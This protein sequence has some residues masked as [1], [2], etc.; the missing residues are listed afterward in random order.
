MEHVV[1]FSTTARTARTARIALEKAKDVR[2]VLLVNEPNL[3]V[4]IDWIEQEA[5][6]SVPLDMAAKAK[7]ILSRS[8]SIKVRSSKKF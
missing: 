6:V 7:E 3:A 1:I 5:C 8:R 2:A 4:R